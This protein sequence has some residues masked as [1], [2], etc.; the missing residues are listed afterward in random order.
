[1]NERIAKMNIF[2]NPQPPLAFLAIKSQKR[3]YVGDEHIFIF[4]FKDFT[5]RG[6]TNN[7][8]IRMH[9][10]YIGK[11]AQKMSTSREGSVYSNMDGVFL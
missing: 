9:G 1:M 10:F 4:G 5:A 7:E 3:Q 11:N 6:L 8:F 2:V